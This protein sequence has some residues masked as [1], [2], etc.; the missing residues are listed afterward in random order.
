MRTPRRRGCIS[1]LFLLVMLC[2]AV[3]YVVAA[4]TSPWAFHINGVPTPL[5]YWSG[6]GTLHAKSGTYPLYV[7]L[8]PAPHFSRLR[9][10]GLRPTGG[11]QGTASLCTSRGVIQ[12]LKVSGTMYNGWSSTEDSLITVRLLERK[13]LDVGQRQGYFDLYGR[14]RGQQLILDDR[15]AWSTAYQ[16]GVRIEHASVTLDRSGYSDFKAACASAPH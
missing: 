8:Y 15:G 10:D 7:L 5:L 11:L 13:Y 3:V 12:P 6:S 16:S 2:V 9:L 14:W 1:Q 4:I